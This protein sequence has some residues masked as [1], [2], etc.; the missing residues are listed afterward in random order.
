MGSGSDAS[1]SE[2][3]WWIYKGISAQTDKHA[4]CADGTFLKEKT[5]RS[6]RQELADSKEWLAQEKSE[7]SWRAFSRE[8][9]D[10]R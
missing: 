6:L 8:D 5:L 9:I 4:N 1:I 2:A 10:I 7:L 3:P